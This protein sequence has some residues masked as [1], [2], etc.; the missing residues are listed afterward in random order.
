MVSRKRCN[1]DEGVLALSS[2]RSICFWDIGMV[3]VVEVSAIISAVGVLVGVV[4]YILDMRNQ[5]HMRRTDL[6]KRK[7][8]VLG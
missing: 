8:G 7:S 1:L 3:D 5:T 6:Q 2:L 4:Y